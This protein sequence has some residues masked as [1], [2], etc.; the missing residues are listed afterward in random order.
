MLTRAVDAL[1]ALFWGSTWDRLELF[2]EPVDHIERAT[3]YEIVH[4][5]FFVRGERTL[6]DVDRGGL[7]L[8]STGLCCTA[9]EDLLVGDRVF[10]TAHGLRRLP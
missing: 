3:L 2:P 10:H 1:A 5:G 6:H 7:V 4:Q 8:T 9:A